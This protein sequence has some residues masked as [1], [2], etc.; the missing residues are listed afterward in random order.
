[1]SLLESGIEQVITTDWCTNLTQRPEETRASDP[2]R[3]G[4]KP[5][6][7]RNNNQQIWWA[8]MGLDSRLELSTKQSLSRFSAEN[9]RELSCSQAKNWLKT[10][11]LG[12]EATE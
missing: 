5:P 11:F 3:S 2:N 6:K 1:M 12:A 9:E 4:K 7:L 10:R 8:G